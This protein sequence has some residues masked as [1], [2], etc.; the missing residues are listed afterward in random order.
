VKTVEDRGPGDTGLFVRNVEAKERRKEND[1]GK[2][3]TV[4]TAKAKILRNSGTIAGKGIY[5]PRPGISVLG[6]IDFLCNHHGYNWFK[7]KK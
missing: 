4:D 3:W 7:E 5:H 2:K 6:A 1:M